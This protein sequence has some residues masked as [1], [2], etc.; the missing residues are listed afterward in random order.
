MANVM[1]WVMRLTLP[2]RR[3]VAQLTPRQAKDYGLGSEAGDYECFV[4]ATLQ[5]T[6]SHIGTIPV[7]VCEF[8]NGCVGNIYTERVSF[9]DTDDKGEIIE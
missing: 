1:P 6:D 5:E 3:A 8:I 7:F 4:L 9:I 2:R